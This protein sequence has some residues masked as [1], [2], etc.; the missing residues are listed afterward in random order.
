M[1]I[2]EFEKKYLGEMVRDGQCVSLFRQYAE[3]CFGI[4]H[5]GPVEGAI[6]IW[7]TRDSNPLIKKYFNIVEGRPRT[8]DIIFFNPIGLGIHDLSEAHRVY[9][10]ALEMGIGR[11]LPLWDEPVLG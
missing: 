9:R 8:G 3:E 4:P 1:N 11:R 7:L 10:N 2:E 6:D 5:T